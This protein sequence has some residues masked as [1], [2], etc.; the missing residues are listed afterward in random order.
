M[1][2]ESGGTASN[3]DYFLGKVF[4]RHLMNQP[5]LNMSKDEAEQTLRALVNNGTIEELGDDQY[6]PVQMQKIQQELNW[7]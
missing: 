2:D 6:R 7:W 3:K 5:A 4:V 1:R